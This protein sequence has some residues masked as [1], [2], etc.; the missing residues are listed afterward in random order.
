MIDVSLVVDLTALVIIAVC[1][2]FYA[3]KGL[4]VSLLDLVGTL[5]A[6]VL[7]VF[8]ASSLAPILFNALFRTNM[9][10]QTATAIQEQGIEHLGD[11]V[12]KLLFFLPPEAVKTIVA[13]FDAA[14]GTSSVEVA[15]RL[16]DEIIAPL[17]IPII[18]VALFVVIFV[19]FTLLLRLLAKTMRK[20]GEEK[21][22]VSKI[23]KVLGLVLGAL[24]GV[25]FAFALGVCL[26]AFR[27]AVGEPVLDTFVYNKSILYRFVISL[28]WFSV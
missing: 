20:A 19:V 16:I 6:L 5:A 24:M 21:S 23:D 2:I 3:K 1:I 11:I 9:E 10:V 4:M 12:G 25:V 18:M 26:W 15:A 28:P 14:L 13:P 7:G 22:L 8:L 27:V 17:V